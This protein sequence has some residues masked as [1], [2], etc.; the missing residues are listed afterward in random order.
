MTI[1]QEKRLQP[2]LL[3]SVLLTLLIL[4]AKNLYPSSNS[5]TPSSGAV[6][7]FVLA[8]NFFPPSELCWV[9]QK[10][11]PLILSDHK[12]GKNMMKF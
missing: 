12:N 3:F 7:Q 9:V 6:W 5:R 10:W 2:I 8:R 1:P 11:S 4:S